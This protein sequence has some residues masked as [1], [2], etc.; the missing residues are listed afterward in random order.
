MCRYDTLEMMSVSCVQKKTT[1]IFSLPLL[2]VLV[3]SF[4]GMISRML[5]LIRRGKR[6]LFVLRVQIISF[7]ASFDLNEKKSTF[8]VNTCSFLEFMFYGFLLMLI[9]Q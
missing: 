3:T 2:S 9:I 7:V 5:C 6:L 1:Y 4:I 8:K